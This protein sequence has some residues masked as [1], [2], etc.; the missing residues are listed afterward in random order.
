MIIDTHFHAFPKK[1]LELVPEQSQ[2]DVRGVGFHGF[3]HQEYLNVM[4]QHGIDVGV[5]SN[6]GGR[7]E[8]GGDRRKALELC[9][10]INDAFAEAQAKHPRPV[11]RVAFAADHLL[12]GFV[13][14][15]T[16]SRPRS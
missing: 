2:S 4:D 5:L 3:D 7:I 8:Q 11:E 13:L 1:F 6:T 15:E 16:R 14:S 12:Y 9:N 10:I